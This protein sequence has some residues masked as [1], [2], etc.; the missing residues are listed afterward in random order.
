MSPIPH[1]F[2]PVWEQKA[3]P[4]IFRDSP[5]HPLLVRLPF[6]EGNREWLQDD[7]RHRPKWLASEKAWS[8]PK[9]WFDDSARRCL[10]RYHAVY[11]IQPFRESETCAPA[12]VNAIGVECTCSCLGANHGSGISMETWYVVSDAFAVRYGPKQYA[13]RLLR[14]YVRSP[15]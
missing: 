14:P 10:E 15:F 3:L 11:I 5:G 13:V 2:A 6:A 8:I 12:C 4:V 9:A 7:R 1:S